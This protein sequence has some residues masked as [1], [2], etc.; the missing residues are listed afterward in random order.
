MRASYPS[1]R[2][3]H[4]GQKVKG[5]EVATRRLPLAVTMLELERS[6]SAKL[7]ELV[8]GAVMAIVE[9]YVGPEGEWTN[10]PE[11]ETA[12]RRHRQGMEA[13]A[14]VLEGVRARLMRA[15]H[16][17]QWKYDRAKLGK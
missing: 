15:S 4:R 1:G 8:R 10:V 17:V 11:G 2:N 7:K 3:V 12:M 6:A 14:D 16:E 9:S 13:V 5:E